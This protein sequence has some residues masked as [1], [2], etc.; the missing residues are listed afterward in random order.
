MKFFKDIII[1]ISDTINKGHG[2]SF[3][4]DAKSVNCHV[5][6][7]GTRHL[8]DKLLLEEKVTENRKDTLKSLLLVLP[9]NAKTS[10][11]RGKGRK[12]VG[13]ALACD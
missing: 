13:I 9:C 12:K 11:K 3:L 8:M 5:H 6:R 1:S 7:H 4:A 10:E 2:K